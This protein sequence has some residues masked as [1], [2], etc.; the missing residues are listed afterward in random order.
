MKGHC[1]AMLNPSQVLIA[2]GFSPISNDFV[3]A[4]RIYDFDSK[5][6]FSKS[7][8]QMKRSRMDGACLNV[9][10]MASRRIIFAGGWSNEAMT[11]TMVSLNE[12]KNLRIVTVLGGRNK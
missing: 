3:A 8:M 7:W 11:E 4:T 9:E 2:G 1:A 12:I 5:S 6:W 10:I